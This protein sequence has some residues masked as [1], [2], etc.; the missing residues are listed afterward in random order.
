MMEM[1]MFKDIKDKRE[2][3]LAI[4]SPGCITVLP[5]CTFKGSF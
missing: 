5:R 1:L 3:E 2:T 4:N